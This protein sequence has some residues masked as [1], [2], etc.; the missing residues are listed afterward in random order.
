ME[1]AIYKKMY[2]LEDKH[3]WFVAR[4]NFVTEFY[5]DKIRD[6]TGILILD[7]GCG[8][9]GLLN[10][11]SNYP[12]SFG[13]DIS[14]LAI[15]FCRKR[16]L[17]KI[18][19]GTITELPFKNDSFD[20]IT[21]LDVLYHKRISDDSKAIREIFR[22]LKND[23]IVLFLEPAYGFL[24][25]YHDKPQHTARRYNASLLREKIKNSGFDI[26]KISY[27]NTSILPMAIMD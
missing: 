17:R 5:K 8:T 16:K 20:L 12:L 7:V 3:W 19:Q 11:L 23:G 25:S 15:S 2:E 13:V 1:Y 24:F 9:G 18:S 22:V 27:I 10:M 4:N 14:D 6:E 26:L 21:S